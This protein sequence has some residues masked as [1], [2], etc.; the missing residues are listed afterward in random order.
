MAWPR[1]GVNIV[2]AGWAMLDGDQL[3]G[4]GPHPLAVPSSTQYCTGLAYGVWLAEV[5]RA[6]PGAARALVE[7]KPTRGRGC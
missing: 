5:I 6:F 3:G 4:A 2:I 1:L 7:G